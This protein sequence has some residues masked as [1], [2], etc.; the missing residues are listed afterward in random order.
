MT[1]KPKQQV[2]RVCAVCLKRHGPIIL[3]VVCYDEFKH[4]RNSID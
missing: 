3:M 2:Y 1:K 4:K